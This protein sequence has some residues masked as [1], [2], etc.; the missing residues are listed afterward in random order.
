[1]RLAGASIY[2][3]A[4]DFV[5]RLGDRARRGCSSH[6]DVFSADRRRR[7]DAGDHHLFADERVDAARWIDACIVHR[8]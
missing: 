7:R 5:S 2:R 8:H 3:S 4:Q 1:M 6:R